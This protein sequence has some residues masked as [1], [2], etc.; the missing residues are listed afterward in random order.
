MA[1]SRAVYA[2][3][4]ANQVVLLHAMPP[5]IAGNY[6]G[7]IVS[8]KPPFE[9]LALLLVE[10]GEPEALQAFLQTKLQVS[11]VVWLLAE[12]AK[13]I[14]VSGSAVSHRQGLAVV[15]CSACLMVRHPAALR[16]MA[17]A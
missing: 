8:A 2:C 6:Y 1:H 17:E 4:C 16:W 3:V 13:H 11:G 5:A 9:E 15:G 14:C 10:S 12:Y 7:R